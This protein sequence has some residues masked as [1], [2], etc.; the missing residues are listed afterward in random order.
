MVSALAPRLLRVA[1]EL[2]DGTILWMAN[3]QVDRD[4]RRSEDQRGGVSRRT[5]GASHRRRPSCRRARRRRGGSRHRREELRQLRRCCPT[6]A[7]SSTSAARRD[8]ADAA[9]V[10]DEAAVTAQIE[11]LFDAGATDVWAAVFPVGDDRA[12]LAGALERLLK[13]LAAA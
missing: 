7:A 2:T 13:E 3:A 11:A 1:G 6:T 9:I 4:A 5:T 10:G 12:H 8:P